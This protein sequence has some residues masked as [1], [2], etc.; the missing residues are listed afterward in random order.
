ML[1]THLNGL[2][3][4]RTSA[5][6]SA[7]ILFSLLSCWSCAHSRSLKAEPCAALP[8]GHLEHLLQRQLSGYRI[9]TPKDLIPFHKAIWERE[10]PQSCPGLTRVDIDGDGKLDVGLNMIKG[11]GGLRLGLLILALRVNQGW[12]LRKLEQYEQNVPAV[13]WSDSDRTII[14]DAYD[15]GDKLRF[16]HGALILVRYESWARAYGIVESDIKWIQLSN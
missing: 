11:A 7:L 15:G 13:L 4:R 6:S 8:K 9:V 12:S 1:S 14:Y 16:S 10:H 5:S 2:D 3:R